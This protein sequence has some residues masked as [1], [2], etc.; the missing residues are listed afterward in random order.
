MRG[1]SNSSLDKLGMS[2]QDEP[3]QEVHRLLKVWTLWDLMDQ[4]RPHEILRPL[5]LLL[6][7]T[8]MCNG[9]PGGRVAPYDRDMFLQL[10]SQISALCASCGLPVA[11][12]HSLRSLG[13]IK[14]DRAT[15]RGMIEMAN[16][17]AQVIEDECSTMVFLSI[18]SRNKLFF[19]D[20]RKGWEQALNRFPETVQ[21]VEEMGKCFAL[22]RFA[23]SVF[24]SVHILEC[25]LLQLGSWLGVADPK[26][27]WTAVANKLRSIASKKHDEL[28]SWEKGHFAFIEQMQ[29]TVEGLKNAWRNKVSHAHGK[30]EVMTADFSDEVAEEI[31]FATR[32]FMR[33]LAVDLPESIPLKTLKTEC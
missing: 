32:A 20:P 13:Y 1:A 16:G 33:R 7:S 29:G 21:D 27:G 15:V 26:S 17:V 4:F 14:A 2:L 11:H 5:R 10:T 28:S 19:D 9:G 22:G 6:R 8:L 12:Q 31:M 30:L 3:I 23:A 24:H 25:G 18:N